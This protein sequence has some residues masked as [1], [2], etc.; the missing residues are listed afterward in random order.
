SPPFRRDTDQPA[1][2]SASGRSLP[3]AMSRF[4]VSVS[5]SM[6]AAES[7]AAHT[8]SSANG[9]V[10]PPAA[11]TRATAASG[12]AALQSRL[13]TWLATDEPV[14]RY[15][16]PYC[17]PITRSEERRVGKECRSRWSQ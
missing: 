2:A 13:L 17:S 15:S 11:L 8:I 3:A 16:A 14:Y 6:H 12:V 5:D 4:L 10:C 1:G 7:R 9:H